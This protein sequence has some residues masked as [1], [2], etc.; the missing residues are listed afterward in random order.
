MLRT[1]EE[2]AYNLDGKKA[3]LHLEVG[4]RHYFKGA[5]TF[6]F[7]IDVSLPNGTV[8]IRHRAM[9]KIATFK[10]VF[11][12]LTIQEFEE[13]LP[14]LMLE[15]IERANSVEPTCLLGLR[16]EDLE[17]YEMPEIVATP[18]MLP[19]LNTNPAN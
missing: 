3:I 15:Q 6:G 9:F 12:H 11:G 18:V 14:T 2:K 16:Q 17:L 5:K 4:E 10:K 19:P 8:V 7:D 1:K 13:T